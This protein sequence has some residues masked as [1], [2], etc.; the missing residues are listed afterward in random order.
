MDLV[1]QTNRMQLSMAEEEAVEAKAE[2]EDSSVDPVEVNIEVVGVEIRIGAT[3]KTRHKPIRATARIRQ[4]EEAT[5]AEDAAE[6]ED[7][8]VAQI[9]AEAES[10]VI[11]VVSQTTTIQVNAHTMPDRAETSSVSI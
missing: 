8:V 6:L 4:E 10:T 2:E 5:E 3:T 9:K 11:Y 7:V 1:P